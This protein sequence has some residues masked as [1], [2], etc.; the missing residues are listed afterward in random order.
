MIRIKVNNL[1]EPYIISLLYKASQAGVKIR[2]IVRSICCLIPGMHGSSENI[3]VKRLVDRYLEHSRLLIFGAGD[4]A[5]VIM[6][7]ADLM[8]RNLYQRIEVCVAIK[9]SSIRK[10]LIDYFEMQ[11]KDND[12]SVRLL[13][14]L[15][16]KR[17]E[18]SGERFNAQRAI[19]NYLQNKS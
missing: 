4:E 14:D 1:E 19:Y 6:G 11:W 18:T 17:E 13:P 12:K 5:E 2:M 8:T 10:E 3:E 16:Q 7:S 9:N 15:Q